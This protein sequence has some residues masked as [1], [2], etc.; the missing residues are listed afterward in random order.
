M[1]LIHLCSQT[2]ITIVDIYFYKKDT[3]IQTEKLKHAKIKQLH[4][5]SRNKLK[6][7]LT[8]IYTDIQIQKYRHTKI[9]TDRH[10]DKQIYRQTDRQTD[11]QTDRH[12]QSNRY[13]DK[14]LQTDRLTVGQP[15]R[16][17]DRQ[18]D[19]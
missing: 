2:Q 3:S 13:T 14:T 9:K 12:R 1:R 17:T 11:W 10:T 16:Q 6:I 15:Y 4:K 5:Q 7:R 8:D 19:R 18:P